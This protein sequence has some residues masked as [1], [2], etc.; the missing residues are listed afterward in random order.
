MGY[1]G[2]QLKDLEET[3]NQVPCDAVIIGTP[4]DLR[5][6]VRDHEALHQGAVFPGG[7]DEARSCRYP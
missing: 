3:I 5:R 1:G 6:I 7:T 4:I 2:E